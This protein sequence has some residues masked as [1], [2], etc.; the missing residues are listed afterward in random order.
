MSEE[1]GKIDDLRK[2]IIDRIKKDQKKAKKEIINIA[3]QGLYALE[4]KN[5]DVR[6]AIQRLLVSKYLNDLY[7]APKK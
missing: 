7:K 6:R 3:D 4:G 5:P 1:E 2:A